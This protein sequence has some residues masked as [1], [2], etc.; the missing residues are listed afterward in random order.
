MPRSLPKPCSAP[1]CPQLVRTGR[2]DEHQRKAEELRGSSADRGYA[3]SGHLT[4]REAVLARDPICVCC[5][6]R[7][8]TEADHHPVSR[9]GL[10]TLGLNPDDPKRGRGLCK[11]CHS[12]ETAKNQPGGWN[13]KQ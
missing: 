2:C 8:S 9:K 10:I 4:F 13:R 12:S 5:M 3:S 11:S 7:P 6:R 1:G